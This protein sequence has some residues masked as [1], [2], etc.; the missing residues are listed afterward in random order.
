VMLTVA[1]ACDLLKFSA[2]FTPGVGSTTKLES[3]VDEHTCLLSTVVP[4][5]ARTGT[6]D[7]LHPDSETIY[8]SKE[9]FTIPCPDE[10][11]AGT[12]GGAHLEETDA[13]AGTPAA[14]VPQGSV[15]GA[16]T[17]SLSE[18]KVCPGATIHA[19]GSNLR[20]KTCMKIGDVEFSS[21]SSGGTAIVPQN[22]PTGPQ[23][24]TIEAAGGSVDVPIT[25]TPGQ[26]PDVTSVTPQA[27]TEGQ[28]V[29][30]TGVG[31]QGVT[32]VTVAHDSQP[33]GKSAT[34]KTNTGTTITFDVPAGLTPGPYHV[35]VYK[36]DCGISE[37]KLTIQ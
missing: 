32:S 15:S 34:V 24:L 35:T 13:E 31:F 9:A 29:T 5:G 23:T 7:V 27:A 28:E 20:T 12:D 10:P 11:E 22:V 8:S 25:I 2:T 6:I 14:C 36:P 30:L 3:S 18:S 19:F 4:A 1:R 37:P 33:I 16:P 21:T 17:A 26:A